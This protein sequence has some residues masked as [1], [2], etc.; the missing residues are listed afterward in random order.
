[1]S[2]AVEDGASAPE[3]DDEEIESINAVLAHNRQTPFSKGV[4]RRTTATPNP[5]GAGSNGNGQSW[6]F[7]ANTAI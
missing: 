3:D 4:N 6:E 7:S 2:A 1:M 5:S